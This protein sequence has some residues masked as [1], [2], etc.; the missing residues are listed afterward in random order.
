MPAASEQHL[1]LADDVEQDKLLLIINRAHIWRRLVDE[2]HHN[3]L[4]ELM[5]SRYYM[6]LGS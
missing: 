3:A 5:I 1:Y 2:V 4:C 6:S